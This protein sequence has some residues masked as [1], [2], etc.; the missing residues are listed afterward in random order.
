MSAI[1]DRRKK[2][3]GK[4]RRKSENRRDSDI[5]FATAQSP[6]PV[7]VQSRISVLRLQRDDIDRQIAA[8]TGQLEPP[9]ITEG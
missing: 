4:E 6:D 7:A 3:Q 9:A 2:W 5:D 8:L 1:V